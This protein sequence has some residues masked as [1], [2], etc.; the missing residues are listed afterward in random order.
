MEQINMKDIAIYGAGGFGREVACLLHRINTVNPQ[1]NFIGFFDDVQ[2][3]GSSNEY[4]TVLGNIDVLNAWEAPLS[5]VFAIGS[6]KAVF[7][8][9][10]KINNP[11]IEFPNIIAPDLVLFDPNN[12][13]M[14]IGNVI[15]SKC[16][17]SCNVEIGNFNIF[18]GSVNVG[19]DS[20]IGDYNSIMP[21]VCISGGVHIGERNFIGVNSV[22]LQYNTIGN[23]TTVG[24]GSVIIRNTKNDSTY[25]GNPATK[26][27][28]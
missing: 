28:Y 7:T 16:L 24:A 18:N 17:I 20:V 6:P 9:H 23:D 1:W 10:S 19:H 26:I 4:G 13:R 22:I 12:I 8:I 27:K 11:Q 5:V 2:T 21:A 3:Q 14:G 15:C 25:V